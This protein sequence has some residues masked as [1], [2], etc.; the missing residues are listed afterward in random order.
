MEYYTSVKINELE[1]S[2]SEIYQKF[3]VEPEKQIVEWA[4]QCDTTYIK[5][6]NK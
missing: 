3:K 2:A 6:K 4:V 1:A 5:F